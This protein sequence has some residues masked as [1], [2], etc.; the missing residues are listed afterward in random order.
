MASIIDTA[1]NTGSFELVRDR[2]AA[3][4]ADELPS[5]ATIQSDENLA[6]KGVF[7]ERF[8]PFS[9]TDC[10]SVNVSI[11]T[12]EYS[13]FTRLRQDGTYQF[14]IDVYEK[15]S[16]IS[17][18][19]GDKLASIKLQK[20]ANVC[21]GILSHP[22][23]NTLAFAA[24]FIEHTEIKSIGFGAPNGSSESEN[25]VMARMIFEVR[26]PEN[27]DA[28][29]PLDIAGYTTKA[30]L[31][32]TDKGYLYGGDA[33]VPPVAPICAGVDFYVND[34]FQ[35]TEDSGGSIYFETG[36]C[37]DAN[38]TVNGD[39][40]GVVASGGTLPITV[41]YE[42]SLDNPIQSIVG[43]SII[44]T[45][46]VVIPTNKIYIRPIPTGEV[47]VVASALFPDGCD[48]WLTFTG[49]DPFT[50]PTN[51]V[52]MLLASPT[53]LIPD[54]VFNSKHRF[55][56]LSGGYV[57]FSTGTY[58]LVDGTTVTQ[59]EAFPDGL[60]ID[61]H[62]GLRWTN[63]QVGTTNYTWYEALPLVEGHTQGGYSDF[64]VPIQKMMDSIFNLN[65]QS[66]FGSSGD[67]NPLFT[68]DITN[69]NKW[70]SSTIKGIETRAW[71]YGTNGAS[72]S[73][74][75]KTGIGRVMAFA[76]HF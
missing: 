33:F 6:V 44:I 42:T 1:I 28:S 38:V 9:H 3:I 32:L 30:V 65:Y 48:S 11:N 54:N 57:D 35:Y 67:K 75:L 50:Q 70:T 14:F 22:K 24:P 10:P 29:T 60:I 26:V 16:A 63:G 31:G 18:D 19:R 13:S 59:S 8:V 52:P 64:H 68:I 62:T 66:A 40:F 55:T 61:H 46:P 23:Y 27:S 49:A 25:M 58:H 76:F 45:D 37:A 51:G 20:L 4:L 71:A 2:I 34:I 73:G 15:S 39:A 36:I 41:E 74:L 21:R 53:E 47:Y 17:E 5:Q 69:G 72:S 12:G 7:I 56:G 43:T